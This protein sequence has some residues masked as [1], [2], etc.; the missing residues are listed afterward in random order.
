M[1][2]LVVWRLLVGLSCKE[3]GY[4]RSCMVGK[5]TEDKTKDNSEDELKEIKKDNLEEEL[6]EL[7]YLLEK[8]EGLKDYYVL[9]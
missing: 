2:I 5:S 7:K 6:E 4:K 9:D 8:V 1:L 3:V